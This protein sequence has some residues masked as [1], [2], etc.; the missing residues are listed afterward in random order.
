MCVESVWLRAVEDKTC[1]SG[2]M[3]ASHS[4]YKLH[5]IKQFVLI[6]N[7]Q[8]SENERRSY[9]PHLAWKKRVRAARKKTRNSNVLKCGDERIVFGFVLL[10]LVFGSA[11]LCAAVVMNCERDTR[12]RHLH[13]E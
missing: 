12:V 6:F 7:F 8:R 13:T 10:A 3:C 5:I 4:D 11:G 2:R 9:R 1:L